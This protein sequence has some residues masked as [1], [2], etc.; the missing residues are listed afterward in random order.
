MGWLLDPSLLSIL[1][2][3]FVLLYALGLRRRLATGR[4]RAELWKRTGLLAAA[5]VL[6]DLVLSPAFDRYAAESQAMHMLQHVVLMAIVPPLVVL[7]A[8]WLTVWRALPLDARRSTARAV[9]RLPAGVRRALRGL[10]S[11][12]VAFVLVSADLA[13]WHVPGLYDLTLRNAVVHDLE[14]ASFLLFGTFYWL[15]LLDSPP[16]RSR[17]DNLQRAIYAGAG[18]ITGWLLALVLAFASTPLYSA[19]AD[20][21]RRLGGLSALSD[22]AL[23]AGVMLGIGSI[24]YTVAVFVFVYRWLEEPRPLTRRTALTTSPDR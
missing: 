19:Y 2:L 12:V 23:A 9:L 17:L 21:P 10:V 11:P 15:A 18:M 7:A 24:P 3:A 16:M 4:R 22:Q 5:F 13:V 6:L 8:P 1:V 20:L 14:H